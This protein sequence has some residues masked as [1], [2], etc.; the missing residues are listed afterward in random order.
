MSHEITRQ[1]P[2]QLLTSHISHYIEVNTLTLDARTKFLMA[3]SL[4]DFVVDAIHKF[5]A[6]QKEHGGRLQDRDLLGELYKENIDSFFY[7]VAQKWKE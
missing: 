6:G 7:I 5:E 3:N 4:S 1:S 2:E